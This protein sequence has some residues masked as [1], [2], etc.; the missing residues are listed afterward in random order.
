MKHTIESSQSTLITDTQEFKLWFA[1]SQTINETGSPLILYHGT[2]SA[3]ETFDKSKIGTNEGTRGLGH[4]FYFTKYLHEAKEYASETGFIMPAYISAKK[5][6]DTN[7]PTVTKIEIKKL[8]KKY[9]PIIQQN[10]WGNTDGIDLYKD[11]LTEKAIYKGEIDGYGV[12]TLTKLLADELKIPSSAFMKELGYDSIKD[13][14]HYLIFEPEQIK[15]INQ[16]QI[17]STENSTSSIK[18]SGK[19]PHLSKSKDPIIEYQNQTKALLQSGYPTTNIDKT[20]IITMIER[21]YKSHQIEKA[22]T[23][24]PTLSTE[25]KQ[26]KLL[27]TQIA[28]E[29][30]HKSNER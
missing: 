29:M 7:N 21:G 1:N 5:I 16:T 15:I 20:I 17:L 11:Y 19:Q 8:I 25:P 13:G 4:G 10:K 22:L 26:A 14:S 12:I 2:E 6:Y 18:I 23:V 3:F 27:I 30:K 24:S 28:K 9:A